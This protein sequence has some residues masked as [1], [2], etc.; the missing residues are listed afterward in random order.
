M[1]ALCARSAMWDNV[2]AYMC[3]A[4][5]FPKLMVGRWIV[6]D[7]SAHCHAIRKA[8]DAYKIGVIMRPDLDNIRGA[9]YV[10]GTIG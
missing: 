4:C 5:L 1:R 3:V 10:P 9:A 7:R 6:T 8:R 2:R